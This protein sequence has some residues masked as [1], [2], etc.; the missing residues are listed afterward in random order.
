MSLTV[1]CKRFLMCC[2]CCSEDKRTSSLRH[3]LH[4]RNI[5]R[6]AASV[7]ADIKAAETMILKEELKQRMRVLRRLGYISEDGVVSTKGHVCYLISLLPTNQ[8]SYQLPSTMPPC[9]GDFLG[10]KRVLSHLM[11][12]R[13]CD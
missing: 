10:L 6:L 3:L 9:H 4:K 8:S 7:R 13:I 1:R 5:E 2:C 12:L 11:H